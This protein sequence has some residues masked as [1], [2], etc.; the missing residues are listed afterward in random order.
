MS[1][2]GVDTG[3][4]ARECTRTGGTGV[5]LAEDII[6]ARGR[7]TARGRCYRGATARPCALASDGLAVIFSRFVTISGERGAGVDLSGACRASSVRPFLRSGLASARGDK[8]AALDGSFPAAE[9]DAASQQLINQLIEEDAQTLRRKR[10][11]EEAS[12]RAA[13]RLEEEERAEMRRQEEADQ[14]LARQLEMSD[15]AASKSSREEAPAAPTHARGGAEHDGSRQ[16]GS[17]K[18]SRGSEQDVVEILSG[19]EDLPPPKDES[20]PAS[21][22]LNGLVDGEEGCAARQRGTSKVGVPTQGAAH[23]E[24][25]NGYDTGAVSTAARVE[26]NGSEGRAQS[27][28]LP[29]GKESRESRALQI[30]RVKGAGVD[31]GGSD[32]AACDIAQEAGCDRVHGVSI[33]SHTNGGRV[34]QRGQHDIDSGGAETEAGR[35]GKRAKFDDKRSIDSTRAAGSAAAHG[36]GSPCVSAADYQMQGRETRAG[37][38]RRSCRAEDQVYKCHVLERMASSWE[39]FDPLKATHFKGPPRDEADT[40]ITK[41]TEILLTSCYDEALSHHANAPVEIHERSEADKITGNAQ[42]EY[43]AIGENPEVKLHTCRED[44]AAVLGLTM[45][46]DYRAYLNVYLTDA[47]VRQRVL[48]Q[49][50]DKVYTFGDGDG[51]GGHTHN[52]RTLPGGLVVKPKGKFCQIFWNPNLETCSGTHWDDNASLL[53]MLQGKKTVELAPETAGLEPWPSNSEGCRHFSK[54]A[55]STMEQSDTIELLPGDALFLPARVWHRG[56]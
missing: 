1:C 13:R 27:F 26:L 29:D 55:P 36:R 46:Q 7:R 35:K 10:E 38:A 51:D 31:D 52:L 42:E 25:G 43:C 56:E 4:P 53:C 47:K 50:A 48:D 11:E 44:V 12:V 15:E 2:C 54:T 34:K 32:G 8:M 24:I 18:T 28:V 5:D 40:P 39:D 33:F 45:E 17:S 3:V 6:Y 37:A 19:D 21:R 23:S 22:W 49:V 20:P 41:I 9:N 30:P 16:D 14:E